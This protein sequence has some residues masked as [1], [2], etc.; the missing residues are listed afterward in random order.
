MRFRQAAKFL[1]LSVFASLLAHAPLAANDSRE[2]V[3]ATATAGK[4]QADGKQT[5]TVTL[6]I[7]K[8]WHIY[9]NPVKNENFEEIRT[10]VQ[11]RG[12]TKLNKVEVKYPAGKF[13]KD[14]FTE[15]MVYMDKVEIQAVIQRMPGD[16]RPLDVEV[17]FSACNESRCLTPGTVLGFVTGEGTVPLK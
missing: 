2:K 10:K 8:G 17:F 14:K 11:I 12:K 7:E 3:M 6:V 16:T 15:C 9:A 1:I 5:I 4:I 13:Y